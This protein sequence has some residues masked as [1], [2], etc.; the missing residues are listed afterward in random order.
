MTK[1][2]DGVGDVAHNFLVSC[3]P[4]YQE[5]LDLG[6][7]LCFFLRFFKNGFVIIIPPTAQNPKGPAVFCLDL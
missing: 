5:K 4:T 2:G 7:N 1:S 3:I 6:L